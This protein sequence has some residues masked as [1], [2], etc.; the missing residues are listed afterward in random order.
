MVAY[1]RAVVE[2]Q[3]TAEAVNSAWPFVAP[4]AAGALAVRLLRR[5]PKV[6]ARLPA[7]NAGTKSETAEM[8]VR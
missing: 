7:N 8:H 3:I 5:M 1:V 4:G 2:R 6:Q